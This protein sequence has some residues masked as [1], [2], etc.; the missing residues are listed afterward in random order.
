MKGSLIPKFRW[1]RELW[2][3]TPVSFIIELPSYNQP[4]QKRTSQTLSNYPFFP[5]FSPLSLS[6]PHFPFPSPFCLFLLPSIFLFFFP[7]LLPPPSLYPSFLSPVY[8][9]ITPLSLPPFF[10]PLLNFLFSTFLCLSPP[11]LSPFISLLLS[12]NIYFPRLLLVNAMTKQPGLTP[13]PSSLSHFFPPLTSSSLLSFIFILSFST[14]SHSAFLSIYSQSHYLYIV[15]SY[16]PSYPF[17]LSLSLSLSLSPSIVLP[18]PF[19]VINQAWS[20]QQLRTR[21]SNLLLFRVQNMIWETLQIYILLDHFKT[22]KEPPLP[23]SLML[24]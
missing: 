3:V 23:V 15:I 1:N 6:L 9:T 12:L 5:I 16:S 8:P 4:C 2:G 10:P 21:K 18:H 11:S 20:G 14:P 7:F 24:V 22:A 19:C 13:H 17:S